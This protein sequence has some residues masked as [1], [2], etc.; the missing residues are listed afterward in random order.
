MTQFGLQS[1]P[2]EKTE[3]FFFHSKRASEPHL[4]FVLTAHC[5]LS[6]LLTFLLSIEER[7]P[8]AV[9]AMPYHEWLLG[10]KPVR[11]KQLMQATYLFKQN[12]A[13]S[14]NDRYMLVTTFDS[15]HR[16][17]LLVKPLY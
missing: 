17:K 13:Q 7:P 8:P 11:L 12:M 5:L 2:A 10:D 14:D 4:G 16:P 1:V 9:A 15:T 6:H 3:E